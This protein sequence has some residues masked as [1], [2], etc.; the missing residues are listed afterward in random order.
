[1]SDEDKRPGRRSEPRVWLYTEHW[2]WGSTRTEMTLEE[3]AVF[4]DLL[5]LGITGMGKVDITYPDQLAAQL[6]VPI[7][8][9][10]SCVAKGIKNGKFRI[11]N[12][13]RH[14]TDFKTYLIILNWKRYQPEYLH[15]R[16]EKSTKRTR[17]DKGVKHD[18]H[19]DDRGEGREFSEKGREEKD[20]KVPP[21]NSLS[22]SPPFLS[23]EE[24]LKK[25]EGKTL[26]AA[27]LNI[28][29][30]YSEYPFNNE[31][32]ELLFNI[33]VV[34]YPGINLLEQTA[35]K[36]KW[37]REH[38]TAIEA[39]PRGQ[40]QKFFAEE[41]EFK[42]RGGPMTVGEVLIADKD[43]AHFLEGIIPKPKK[44]KEREE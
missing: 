36:I 37:W 21:K 16:P 7:A 30:Q 18:A 8:I 25:G 29:R 6:M 23:K 24:E 38:P 33:S 12:F 14:L 13:K 31:L 4:I 15:D 1:M 9:F 5:C 27:F 32:D 43:H 22:F 17:S 3:R 44:K 39:D 40:L 41:V 10:N 35:K 20:Q 19:V 11:K 42:K 34:N 2:L 28:L 26:K